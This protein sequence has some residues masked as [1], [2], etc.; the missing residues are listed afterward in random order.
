MATGAASWG[1]CNVVGTWHNQDGSNKDGTYTVTVPN[2]VCNATDDVI[3]PAGQFA[4]GELVT[5]LGQKSLDLDLPANDDPDNSPVDWGQI[6]VVV[7]FK[8]KS[9][10]ETYVID[11][12]LNGTV[13]LR[14]VVLAANSPTQAPFLVRGVPGGV[15]GLNADGD[16]IDA[17]GDVVG[18]GGGGG[19]SITDVTV[20]TLSAGSEATADIDGTTLELG[21]PQGAA[22]SDGADG[23]KGDTGAT[24]AKGDPGVG[25]PAGGTAGQIMTKNSSTD[26]DSGWIDPPAAQVQSDW[27]AS[28]GMGQILNKPTLGTAAAQAVSA[29]APATTGTSIL[30]GDGSGGTTAATAGTDYVAPTALA[31]VATTGSANDLTQLVAAT[32][33][34]FGSYMVPI[35]YDDAGSAWPTLNAWMTTQASVSWFFIGGSEADPPPTTMTGSAVWDRPTA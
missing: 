34:A 14:N 27:N 7:T 3:I 20:T 23:A 2:R 5:T 32:I 17:A 13:N 15:A 11:T 4:A 9:K 28:T 29:F 8:D 22:G 21:I 33:T 35:T 10:T 31:T 12:P 19:S 30:K 1:T 25:V 16:V 18:S 26:Y 6:Q 24:G